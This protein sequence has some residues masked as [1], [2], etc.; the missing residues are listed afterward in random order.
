[1]D[2]EKL[3]FRMYRCL[4]AAAN[5]RT[6]GMRRRIILVIDGVDRLRKNE[7]YADMNW[8][9]KKVPKGVRIIM[10]C[11]EMPS[12]KHR[13]LRMLPLNTLDDETCKAMIRSS[14]TDNEIRLQATNMI[15]GFEE[16]QASVLFVHLCIQALNSALQNV[17]SRAA[18]VQTC[19]SSKTIDGVFQNL[20]SIWSEV[21][22]TK[23]NEAG[24][25]GRHETSCDESSGHCNAELQKVIPLMVGQSGELSLLFPS[26]PLN[27]SS[28]VTSP[29]AFLHYSCNTP[30]VYW[31]WQDMASTKM[32]SI[33]CWV[34]Q[35]QPI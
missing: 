4:E 33:S 17:R 5:S 35:F 15:L 20:I 8:L 1:M 11:R 2:E 19:L 16:G 9:P 23:Y 10:S 28:N 34:A 18:A 12:L 6:G 29:F 3:Q 32:N 22:V 27:V 26:F 30:S 21:L 14:I 24:M 31:L 7:G 13:N 25:G